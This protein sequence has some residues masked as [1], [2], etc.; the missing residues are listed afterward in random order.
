MLPPEDSASTNFATRAKSS[1]QQIYQIHLWF[2][3]ASLNN[4]AC[5]GK[6]QPQSQESLLYKL[7]DESKGCLQSGVQLL[8]LY[9]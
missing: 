2:M 6:N 8:W 9:D 1:G 5:P 3:V 7:K 4:F